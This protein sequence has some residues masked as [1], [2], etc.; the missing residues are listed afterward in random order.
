M[1]DERIGYGNSGRQTIGDHSGNTGDTTHIYGGSQDQYRKLMGWSANSPRLEVCEYSSE[2]DQVR[3]AISVQFDVP[4]RDVENAIRRVLKI[5]PS[6]TWEA[7][8]IYLTD[9]YQ[10][11]RNAFYAFLAKC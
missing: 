6:G 10:R 8:A 1:G 3:L 4:A 5:V 9:D 2:L 11:R 7:R